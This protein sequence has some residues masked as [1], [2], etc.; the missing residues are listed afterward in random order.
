VARFR[1]R[2]FLRGAAAAGLVGVGAA[3]PNARGVQAASARPPAGAYGPRVVVEWMARLVD[4]VRAE[5]LSP[6]VASR[7][8]AYAGVTL[9]EA[10]VG[11]MPGHRSLASQLTGLPPMPPAAVQPDDWEA[12][13]A[14]ALATVAGG[15]VPWRSPDTSVGFGRLLEDQRSRRLAE[16]GAADRLGNALSWGAAVGRA[17]LDW[18]ATDGF[19]ATRGRPYAL[20]VGPDLWVP[21]P[22]TFVAAL[23][24]HW[25]EL[26]PFVLA[27]GGECPPGPPLPYSE[28]PGSAFHEQT[29]RVAEAVRGMTPERLEIARFWADDPGQTGTPP[30][31]WV[32]IVGQLIG[33]RGL[34]LDAAA[35]LYA[36][37]GVALGD[38]FI[39][40]WHAKYRANLLRPVTYIRRQIDPKWGPLLMTP[41]FPEYP[42]GHS[43]ASAAAA[44]VLTVLLGETSF[45]DRTPAT[46]GLRPRTFSSFRAAAAE[47][48]L[49]RLYG[50]IH[51]L[52][53]LGLAVGQLVPVHGP[54]ER[55]DGPLLLPGA[56]LSPGAEPF[57]QRRSRRIRRRGREPLRLRRE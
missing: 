18:A 5:R 22:P 33:E 36:R 38:A 52:R 16:G 46:R 56:L 27:S 8:Y 10:V 9:Y 21:T 14:A 42:S 53:H 48:A 57:H 26:R 50:G 3:A 17:I 32:A 12:S 35:E 47:A 15:I 7:V 41:P 30:G 31:H 11:G 25:G 1:R 23:E 34:R 49:S 4:R 39:A 54:R 28:E 2:D 29:R 55:W 51:Y 24:P 45:T 40:C 44:E 13:A 6:P 43:V 37:V 20:P 19:A